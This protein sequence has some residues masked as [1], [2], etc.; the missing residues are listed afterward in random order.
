MVENEDVK[1]DAIELQMNERNK[2][3]LELRDRG[4]VQAAKALLERNSNE[5]SG[6]QKK[7]KNAPKLRK[8]EESNLEDSKSIEN[9]GE[10]QRSRKAMK[11]K[12]FS[13]DN[14]QAF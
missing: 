13:F 7:Y 2:E 8:L 4:D 12:Q 1:V 5:I 10:W 9:E 11:K 3:A 6:Y 14:Q